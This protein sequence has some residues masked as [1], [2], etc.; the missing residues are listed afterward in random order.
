MRVGLSERPKPIRSGASTRC[1][2]AESG[3]IMVR[4]R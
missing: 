2:A 3:G 4:Y 1:P